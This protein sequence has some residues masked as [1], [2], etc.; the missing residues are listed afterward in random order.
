[1]RKMHF[2]QM[3][4]GILRILTEN[5]RVGTQATIPWLEKTA[6]GKRIRDEQERLRVKGTVVFKFNPDLDL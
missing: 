5:S 3:I 1:M 6:R 2:S 4:V